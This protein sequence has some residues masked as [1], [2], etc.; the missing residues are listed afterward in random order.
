M[1]LQEQLQAKLAEARG[2]LAD[3]KVPEAKAARE[4]AEALVQAIDEGKALDAVSS[5]YAPV[6]PTLPNTQGQEGVVP[7]VAEAESAKSRSGSTAVLE[8]GDGDDG[9]DLV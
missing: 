7:N 4:Q 9:D 2:L 1:T 6:R 5:K 3:G 8:S